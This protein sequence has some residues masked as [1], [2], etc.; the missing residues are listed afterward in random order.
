MKS[1]K[2]GHVP[3]NACDANN[4]DPRIVPE[5][6]KGLWVVEKRLITLVQLSPVI[7]PGRQTA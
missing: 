5:C 4:L 1:I 6:L 3:K 7:L 2:K